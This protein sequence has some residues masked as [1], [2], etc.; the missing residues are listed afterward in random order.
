MSLACN[1][2]I[3]SFCH[4]SFKLNYSNVDSSE[5]SVRYFLI[6]MGEAEWQFIKPRLSEFWRNLAV[7]QGWPAPLF[8]QGIAFD[9][10]RESWLCPAPLLASG[11]SHPTYLFQFQ[12]ATYSFKVS[13]PS[14]PLIE[15][16]VSNLPPD[17]E[18]FKSAL[19]AAFSE[20]GFDG[21][22]SSPKLAFT[23]YFQ[24]IDTESN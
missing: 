3:L 13:N 9:S 18:G 8:C 10:E 16:V 2:C 11:S 1:R 6:P 21:L 24:K 4:A 23:P 14:A 17:Y 22:T 7:R 12:G 19:V 5:D 15:F 20:Y